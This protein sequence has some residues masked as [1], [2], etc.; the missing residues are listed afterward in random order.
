MT[1]PSDIFLGPV[2]GLIPVAGI[3]DPSQRQLLVPAALQR[4]ET[5]VLAQMVDQELD[6]RGIDHV[7]EVIGLSRGGLSIAA[8]MA[9]ANEHTRVSS[10]QIS[11]YDEFN[12]PYA[13]PRIVRA[14]DTSMM[15]KHGVV[16]IADDLVDTGAGLDL[17]V[18]WAIKQ[19]D[20]RVIL[21]AVLRTK[22]RH[23]IMEA[24]VSIMDTRDEWNDYVLQA[25]SQRRAMRLA[26][27]CSSKGYIAR[28]M[29][30]LEFAPVDRFWLLD[31]IAKS[32]G[33]YT[34]PN[35][36]PGDNIPTQSN[37]KLVSLAR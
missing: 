35:S 14:P 28:A 18:R 17:A 4:Y 15:V 32:A 13:E 7:D 22:R 1:N 25:S 6:H 30:I 37:G 9:Y 10:L 16:V 24:D 23:H 34:F 27:L 26:E 11:G 5:L 12:K 2:D 29:G 36:L 31:F 21:T 8:E 20:P 33:V 19:L 3:E